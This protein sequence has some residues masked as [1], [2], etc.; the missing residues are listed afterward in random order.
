MISTTFSDEQQYDVEK[1]IKTDTLRNSNS[2]GL[3]V[4]KLLFDGEVLI[5][6]FQLTELGFFGETFFEDE[7]NFDIVEYTDKYKFKPQYLAKEYYGNPRLSYLIL[8]ANNL[9]DIT[10]FKNDYLSAGIKVIKFSVL[11]RIS[12]LIDSRNRFTEQIEPMNDIT[13]YK[14]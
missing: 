13:I 14:L 8:Y 5:E 12:N 1:A 11:I 10:D 4:S 9:S 7:N 2:F 3:P 6:P